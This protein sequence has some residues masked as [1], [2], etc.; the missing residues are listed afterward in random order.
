LV[1][2]LGIST[3]SF[4]NGT[5]DQRSSYGGQHRKVASHAIVHGSMMLVKGNETWIE[6]LSIQQWNELA[7]QYLDL[8]YRQCPSYVEQAGRIIG[9]KSELIA[10]R[11]R[12]EIIGICSLRIK[13][14]PLTTLGVAYIHQGPLTII[15][16][17]VSTTAYNRC[18]ETLV[19]Y[20]VHE[21]ALSLRIVPPDLARL[22]SRDLSFVFAQQSFHIRRQPQRRTIMIPLGK[23]LGEIRRT[24]DGKWRNHLSKAQRSNLVVKRS[25]DPEDFGPAALLLDELQKQKG[26]HT[27]Y[28]MRF[29][30]RVQ[31]HASRYEKLILHTAFVD[32]TIAAVNLSTFSG[33]I[34]VNLLSASN[35][36][37]RTTRAAYLLHWRVIELAHEL[38]KRWYDLGGVDPIRNPTV[39]HFKKG[40][41]GFEYTEGPVFEQTPSMNAARGVAFFESIYK[42]TKNA[43][44][45]VSH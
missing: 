12:T 4:G 37:G 16:N 27:P 21:R 26:F 38:N 3:R 25:T 14:V 31:R 44:R 22:L 43:L 28:D 33:E 5:F 30:E 2:R 19:R 18:I 42:S 17:E 10:I 34:A 1:S 11:D 7:P 35:K 45:A 41:N 36:A 29:F 32:G 20:F 39:Y 13:R 15:E 24:L 40:V 8:S 23:E 9:A 6:A